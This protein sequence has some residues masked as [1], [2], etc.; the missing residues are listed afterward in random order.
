VGV[1]IWIRNSGTNRD[2]TEE[3]NTQSSP[4]HSVLTFPC[5]VFVEGT[6]IFWTPTNG[7]PN[8]WW[9]QAVI[10]TVKKGIFFA[11]A[12]QHLVGQ[13]ILIIGA[14]LSHS[15]TTHSVGHIWA[16]DQ[17]LLWQF[18]KLTGH[19]H[20]C[21]RRIRNHSASKRAA[22]THALDRAAIGISKKVI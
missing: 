16:S 2:H 10:Y 8:R 15:D 1:L 21:P 19:R 14:S 11:I 9:P 5:L 20:P 13:R 12:K 22:Q 6:D 17:H 3:C 7:R 4:M 18:T